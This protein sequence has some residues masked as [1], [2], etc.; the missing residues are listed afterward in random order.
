M[1]K[2]YF[3]IKKICI[4][5]LITALLI[6]ISLATAF[7]P[8]EKIVIQFTTGLFVVFCWLIPGSGML[9]V[10][11][12]YGTILDSIARSLITIP[13]TILINILIFIIIKIAP[14]NEIKHFFFLLACCFVF[15]YLPYQWFVT[16]NNL[17]LET[18][19]SSFISEV[20]VDSSQ[21]VVSFVIC[22]IIYFA[23]VKTKLNIT[24]QNQY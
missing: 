24:L 1:N 5:G 20:I 10:G 7:I 9:F 22:E 4:L 19:K 6:A 23:L 16:W 17:S 8:M 2:Y 14:K 11:I 15:M 13:M 21:W 3:S 18:K 12:I